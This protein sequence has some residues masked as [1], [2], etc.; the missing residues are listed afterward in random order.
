[1]PTADD[2][3]ARFAAEFERAARSEAFD[4]SRAALAT[5]DAS[6]R[7]SVRFVLVKAHGP[8]GFTFYTNF[9]SRKANDLAAHPVAAL[10]F[11]WHTTGVQVR[12]AG[13][14]VREDDDVADAYFAS[15]PRGSQI[16]AWASPQSRPIRDRAELEAKV[17]EFAA[18]FADA[19]VPRPPHWGGYRIVP[20]E[21]EFWY[22]RPDRLH[23][24]E[25]FRRSDEGWT[26]TLLAP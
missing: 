1:M 18:R 16:G 2:P 20:D 14:V 25:H 21:I 3:I 26:R 5:V 9:E 4:A 10:A 13:P 11:H 24:R 12:I 15:R 19:Q 7:P 22:E 8:R 6:C 17:A 23:V